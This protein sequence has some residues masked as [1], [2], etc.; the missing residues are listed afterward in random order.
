[1]YTYNMQEFEPN[2]CFQWKMDQYD[3]LN[4]SSQLLDVYYNSVHVYIECWD[5]LVTTPYAQLQ[6]KL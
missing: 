3:W 6:N 5:T 4:L 1:M 2:T